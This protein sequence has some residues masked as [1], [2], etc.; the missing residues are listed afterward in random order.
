MTRQADAVEGRVP[1]DPRPPEPKKLM[2]KLLSGGIWAV[3][4]KAGSAAAALLT[5]AILARLLSPADLGVY[6]LLLSIVLTLSTAAQLGMNY[7]IVRF[8]ADAL[9]RGEGA[10]ARSSLRGAVAVGLLGAVAFALLLLSPL[11]GRV[12]QAVFQLPAAT[13]LLPIAALWLFGT[14]AQNLLAEAFRSMHDIRMA[15]LA[16]GTVTAIVTV[17]VFAIVAAVG[18]MPL[19][20][21]VLVIASIVV[22]MA[23]VSGVWLWSRVTKMP[24]NG[25]SLPWRS[26]LRAGFPLWVTTMTFYVIG[27]VDLWI[28]GAMLGAADVALYGAAARL[29]TTLT[30][31]LLIVNA[32]LPPVIAELYGRGEIERLQAT[33][34]RTASLAA[35]PAVAVMIVLSLFGPQVLGLVYGDFYRSAWF[36]LLILGIGQTVNVFA[37]SCGMALMM[38]GHQDTL[39]ILS[40]FSAVLMV[41]LAML[42]GRT[43]GAAGI[44]VAAATGTAVQNALMWMEARRKT[45]LL[46]HATLRLRWNVEQR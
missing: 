44:A 22:I 27:Q 38:T 20:H 26:L 36:V 3:G 40:V 14:A 8:T 24:R 16:G 9:G 34:Q 5:H 6:F 15:T 29:V 28:V 33:L 17:I 46:T 25:A 12:V 39:M 21:V 35:I 41:G 18:T 23:G 43:W 2:Q 4:G 19:R 13:A 11:S 42:L 37:G 31:P 10:R 32:V 7:A 30:M 1:E 45:G